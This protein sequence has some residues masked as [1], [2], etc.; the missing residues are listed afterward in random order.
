[1]P[2]NT[3]RYLVLFV[4]ILSFGISSAQLAPAQFLGFASPQTITQPAFTN[5][6]CATVGAGVFFNVSNIGQG[7]H[8]VLYQSTGTVTSLSIEIQGSRDGSAG[9]FFRMSEN[10]TAVTSGGV[11][12][13]IYLPVVRIAI[14]SCTGT[15]TISATYTGTSVIGG[16]PVGLFTSSG[17]YSKE[18]AVGRPANLSATFTVPLP[19]GGSGGAVYFTFSAASCSGSTLTV[20]A[21]TDSTHQVTLL[22]AVSLSTSANTQA[23]TIAAIPATIAVVTYTTGCGA[24]AATYDLSFSVGERIVTSDVTVNLT[25]GDLAVDRPANTTATFTVPLPNGGSGGA[26]Y[27]TFSAATCSGSTLT[28][29]AGPDSSHQVTLLNAASLTATANTQAFTIVA[30]PATIA[31][32]TYTTGCAASA[33]TYDLTFA[34]GER[35]ITA[36]LSGTFSGGDTSVTVEASAYICNR[37]VAVNFTAAGAGATQI[38]AGD[39]TA[40]IRLC[41]FTATPSTATS[42]Q[43]QQGTGANC[44]TGT[45]NLTGAYAN[46][47]T[48]ALDFGWWS[49]LLSDYGSN[50]CVNVGAATTVTGVAVYALF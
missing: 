35:I 10:A 25:G 30:L 24:S 45:G 32:V 1:M 42:V 5:Q 8:F 48:M 44:A 38:I 4:F 40:R 46:V 22:S 19:N 16:P 11:Y 49:A 6:S 12:A 9:S 3:Q 39:S 34:F 14:T 17:I 33:A 43:L 20:S 28:V 37:F 50:V 7:V 26:V 27:F 29:S 31:V 13:S 47:A 21:G 23:F 36:N 18:L 41:H 15:G 2:G